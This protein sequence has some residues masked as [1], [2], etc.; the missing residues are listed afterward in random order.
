[1]PN[2]AVCV[3]SWFVE[4]KRKRPIDES[5]N[6]IVWTLLL[7]LFAEIPWLDIILGEPSVGGENSNDN[8]KVEWMHEHI[9]GIRI[10]LE[11]TVD[12]NKS[13]VFI[14]TLFFMIFYS[15]FLL[16]LLL[17][18]LSIVVSCPSLLP[19]P[20]GW[21][22][23]NLFSFRIFIHDLLHCCTVARHIRPFAHILRTFYLLFSFAVNKTVGK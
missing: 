21:F 2:T 17:F 7:I 9:E 18:P 11:R 20:T 23:Y 6:K 19:L 1:M 13:E 3:C 14:A 12:Q 5:G 15:I 8:H 10:S 4:R 22:L 16:L